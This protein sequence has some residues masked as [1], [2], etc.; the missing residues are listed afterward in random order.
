M[1]KAENLWSIRWKVLVDKSPRRL[2]TDNHW[3]HYNEHFDERRNDRHSR[4]FR[5]W[6]KSVIH[7]HDQDLIL[8][9]TSWKTVWIDDLTTDRRDFPCFLEESIRDK[10]RYYWRD[11]LRTDIGI[12]STKTNGHWEKDNRKLSFR[13]SKRHTNK[14]FPVSKYQNLFFVWFFTSRIFRQAALIWLKS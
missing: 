5:L 8:E 7:F 11:D 10:A 2:S 9:W 3:F 1:S 14:R 13:R 4:S 12:D 6:D